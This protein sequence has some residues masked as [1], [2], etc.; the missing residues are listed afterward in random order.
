MLA[1]QSTEFKPQK[2]HERINVAESVE[3]VPFK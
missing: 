1:T 3:A 2:S